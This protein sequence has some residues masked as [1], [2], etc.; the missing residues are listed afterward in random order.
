VY[1]LDTLGSES[2]GWREGRVEDREKKKLEERDNVG[3]T[4]LSRLLIVIGS[5]GYYIL[6]FFFKREWEGTGSPYKFRR[7]KIL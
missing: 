7:C 6:Q 3:G 1:G 5:N 4:M 2:I